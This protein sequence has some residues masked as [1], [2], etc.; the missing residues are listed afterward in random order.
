ML[1]LL[2][3]FSIDEGLFIFDG[4]LGLE[5]DYDTTLSLLGVLSLIFMLS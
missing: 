1:S 5:T 3:V 2:T 4:E